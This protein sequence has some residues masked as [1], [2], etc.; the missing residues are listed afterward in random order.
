MLITITGSKTL[1]DKILSEGQVIS[2]LPQPRSLFVDDNPKK[3]V[4]CDSVSPNTAKLG[5]QPAKRLKMEEI[6][7]TASVKQKF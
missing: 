3:R 2:S 4:H 1:A 5:Y 6:P 7:T